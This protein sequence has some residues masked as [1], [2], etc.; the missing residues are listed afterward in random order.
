MRVKII[1]IGS[2]FPI[3]LFLESGKNAEGRNEKILKN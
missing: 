1:L 2:T 3:Y